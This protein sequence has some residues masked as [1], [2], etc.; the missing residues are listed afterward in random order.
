MSQSQY[1][2]TFIIGTLTSRHAVQNPSK[3]QNDEIQIH[4]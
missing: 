4:F 3:K 1:I 2:L